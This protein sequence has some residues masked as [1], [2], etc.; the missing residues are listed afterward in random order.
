MTDGV[1]KVTDAECRVAPAVSS[2][3][4]SAFPLSTRHTAR[5][6]P[7]VVSGSYVTLSSRTLRTP[8]SAGRFRSRADRVP[9]VS[10][11][12]RH[13][14]YKRVNTQESRITSGYPLRPG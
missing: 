13:R 6:S 12:A 11:E 7:T 9:S 5:R 10:A 8:T 14:Y 4:T 3:T 1:V 2:W